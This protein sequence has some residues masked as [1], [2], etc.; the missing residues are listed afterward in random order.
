MMKKT[1]VPQG[2]N[3]ELK[4]LAKSF[5]Y[6]FRGIRSCIL[7]ER[8][9]RIHL[10]TAFFL[11]LFSPF[12]QF[13]KGEFCLLF[14]TIGLVISCEMMNT[15]VE[16]VVDMVSPSYSRLAQVAKDIAAGAVFVAALASAGVGLILY[17]DWEAIGRI[18]LFFQETPWL[19]LLL[20]FFVLMGLL[21][22]FKGFGL[23]LLKPG[24]KK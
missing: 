13:T 17:L 14:L 11:L 16:A 6:A 18:L 9:M 8:N 23:V 4:G 3:K 7:S 2:V 24:R 1:K 5:T 22:V 20:V 21:F 10:T 12:Y 19:I 15:A